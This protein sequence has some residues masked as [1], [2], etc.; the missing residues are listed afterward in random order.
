MELVVKATNTERTTFSLPHECTT[1]FATA[2]NGSSHIA[3]N[4]FFSRGLLS[5]RLLATLFRRRLR[6]RYVCMYACMTNATA[7][8]RLFLVA[9]RPM[10]IPFKHDTWSHSCNVNSCNVHPPNHCAKPMSKHVSSSCH[11]TNLGEFVDDSN[12]W[13]MKTAAACPKVTGPI[14]MQGRKSTWPQKDR[15]RICS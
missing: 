11:G 7:V 8:R 14:T 15:T 12:W 4:H 5:R 1:T 3:S 9:S 2:S 6:C 13:S 10:L